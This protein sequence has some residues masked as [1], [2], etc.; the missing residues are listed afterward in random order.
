MMNASVEIF[1]IAVEK[2]FKLI[3]KVVNVR[4]EGVTLPYFD[5]RR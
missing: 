2:F 3:L 4:L 1:F 5:V